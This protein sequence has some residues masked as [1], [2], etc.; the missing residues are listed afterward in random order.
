MPAENPPTEG[1][2][3]WLGLLQNRVNQLPDM[4]R[5]MLDNI[6]ETLEA[7]TE[8]GEVSLVDGLVSEVQIRND[9]KLEEVHK[10]YYNA[11]VSGRRPVGDVAELQKAWLDRGGQDVL[12]DFQKLVDEAS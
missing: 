4:N 6:K 12:D 5:D 10:D 3:T 2:C 8:S 11:I 9:S 1:A 7:A